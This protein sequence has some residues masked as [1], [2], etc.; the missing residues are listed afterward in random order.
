MKR[1]V[2]MSV[3]IICFVLLIL[4][5]S[6]SF[7]KKKRIEHIMIHEGASCYQCDVAPGFYG[8]NKDYCDKCTVLRSCHQCDME[9]GFYGRNI[10][11]CEKCAG[12]WY[13]GFSKDAT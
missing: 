5:L 2:Y 13:V 7:I 10:D 6:N 9:P 3:I 4:F 11:Y 8:R 12:Q 1:N